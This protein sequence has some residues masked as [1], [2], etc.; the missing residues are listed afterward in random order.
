MALK[1][2]KISEGNVDVVV[3]VVEKGDVREFQKFGKPGRV[4]NAKVKD[5][6]GEM[7]LTLWNEDIDKVK[8][9]NKIHIKNGYVSEWQGD[10]QLSTGR[11]GELEVVGAEGGAEGNSTEGTSTETPAEPKAAEEPS[12]SEGE[13]INI[14]EEKVE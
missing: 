14:E 5:E 6:S 9:G 13:T 10:P 3:E 12:A 11:F 2:L 4:C 8:V 1:D 7:T